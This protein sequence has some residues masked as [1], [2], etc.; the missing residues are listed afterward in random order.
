MPSFRL[1]IL[2]PEGPV[3][4]EDVRHVGAPGWDGGFG[5]LSRHAPMTAVLKPGILTVTRGETIQEFSIEGGV[6]EIGD[7][8][9]T[10][11]TSRAVPVPPA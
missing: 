2:T 3:C 9:M 7:N 6:V 11:L 4:E 10:V 1:E 8:R 5:V